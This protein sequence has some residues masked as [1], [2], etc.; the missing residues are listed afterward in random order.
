MAA[1]G[2]PLLALLLLLLFLLLPLLLLLH[3]SVLL[4][5]DG[6]R[7]MQSYPGSHITFC[8]ARLIRLNGFLLVLL[9]PTG[10]LP[11]CQSFAF[12]LVPEEQQWLRNKRDG[13]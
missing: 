9:A 7:M 2:L 10:S 6:Q 8:E 11:K 3:S 12:L 4:W 1:D 13:E 5:H